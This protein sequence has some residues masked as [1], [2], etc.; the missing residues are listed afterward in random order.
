MAECLRALERI[1]LE[2]TGLNIT[3]EKR[4]VD[5]PVVRATGIF[6]YH[7]LP[8]VRG[9]NDVQLFAER[10]IDEHRTYTG[11]GSGTLAQFLRHITNRTGRRFVDDTLSSEVDVSWS[12][13]TSSKLDPF[14]SVRDMYRYDLTLLLENVAQQTG[15]TFTTERRTI[16]EWHLHEKPLESGS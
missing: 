3:F 12:D 9:E 10:S 14:Q 8:G 16:D 15:L 6:Q 5:A 1:V 13:Y 7:P 11:G 4:R 2:E